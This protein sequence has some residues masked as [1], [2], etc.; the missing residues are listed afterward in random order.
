MKH[1]YLLPLL[2]SVGAFA[3]SAND[4]LVMEEMVI[5]SNR[6]QIP[7]SEQ[8]RNITIVSAAQIEKLPGKSLNELLS[9][10]SGVDIRQRGPFGTQSDISLDGGSFEQTVILLNGIKI[11]DAQTA[12]NTLNIPLP[13]EAIERLEI[14][15][16][17][18]ARIYG[19]NSL[20]GAINIVT[21]S[22]KESGFFAHLFTGTNFK[23][24]EEGKKEMYNGRGAQIGG[25]F[26]GKNH[27][28]QL[29]GTH[30]SGSGYRYNT[31]YHNNRL[32][33]QSAYEL[34]ENNRIEAMAG[35][36]RSSFGA[37]GFYAAPGDK[38]SKEVVSTTMVALKSH[39]RLSD[40]FTLSPQIGYRYNY[41]DYRYFRHEYS[42]AR[43]QHYTNALTAEVSGN[44]VA[45]FGS[46]GFGAESRYEKIHSSNIGDHERE[47]YGMYAEFRTL[48]LPK[49]DITLGTYINY[50]SSFGWQAFPGLDMSYALNTHFKWILNAGTSQRIPSFTDLYLNQRPGN[51]GNPLLVDEQAYQVETGYKYR[52]N[53]WEAKGFLFYRSIN[54]FID[55]TRE[56][57]DEP[58]QANNVGKNKTVGSNVGV[59]YSSTHWKNSLEYTYLSP[60]MSTTEQRLSKYRLENLK[61]QLVHTLTYQNNGFTALLANRYLN[62]I[63]HADY[64]L[65][66]VRLSY[67]LNS[68][69]YYI[70]GQNLWD[71]TYIEAGAVPM[72]GRWFSIGIKINDT[73]KKN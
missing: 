26:V 20:T 70:D 39:H 72:P 52:K 67:T 53:N 51:I 25:T 4:S 64:F 71:K 47:N 24:D 56:S 65:T 55:W 61:H 63:T 16:G 7:I 17:P 34:N 32:W 2:I 29:Y 40:R 49:M 28:Q 60:K 59:T 12:H 37:N 15:R 48:E 41:D 22:P 3:Q 42:K 30:E 36:V 19:V 6:L 50:N 66:D 10:T 45:S 31:A 21:K 43:S 62:R 18:A 54:H 58:W 11:T 8:N 27:T 35:W 14:L 13:T 1:A 38:E 9:Y 46:F 69:T 5:Q 57:A 33:Y 44:Y 23:K 73:F 68:F